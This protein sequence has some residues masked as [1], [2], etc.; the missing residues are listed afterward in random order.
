MN[1]SEHIVFDQPFTDQNR[2][3]VVV[4]LPRHERDQHVLAERELSLIGRR[5]VGKYVSGLDSVALLGDRLLVY[6]RSLVGTKEFEQ[7]VG[8]DLARIPLDQDFSRG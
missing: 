2:I 3:L 6:A 8:V 5:A 1:R 7:F 4:P